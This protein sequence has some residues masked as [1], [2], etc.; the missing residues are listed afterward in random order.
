MHSVFSIALSQSLAFIANS[1]IFT[2]TLRHLWKPVCGVR[3][4]RYIYWWCRLCLKILD[5]LLD[6][7]MVFRPVVGFIGIGLEKKIK[8]EGRE[9]GVMEGDGRRGRKWKIKGMKNC[10][11]IKIVCTTVYIGVH[12]WIVII[13]V[14]L[15]AWNMVTSRPMTRI[16]LL[17][18]LWAV[19]HCCRELIWVSMALHPSPRD[20]WPS[21]QTL[22]S[23]L[24]EF[25]VFFWF[26]YWC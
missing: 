7:R 11:Q 24:S 21:K 20:L 12:L 19:C 22:Y 1:W 17:Y 3:R 10:L 18:Y 2:D 15:A 6:F 26:C 23:S 25:S 14:K 13:W 9:E 8:N 5:S 16:H 4:D